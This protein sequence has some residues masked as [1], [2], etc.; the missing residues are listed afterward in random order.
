MTDKGLVP[1]EQKKVIFYEDEITAVLIQADSD[2]HVFVPL[3]PLCD[4]LGIDWPAQ[5]QRIRRDDVL[6]EETRSIVVTTTDRGD[7]EMV[8]LPL[9]FLPGWLFTISAKRVKEEFRDKIKR[10]QRECY[11][12]L[13]EAFQEGRLTAEPS[14]DELL[15]RESPAAQ[16]YR[17]ASAIMRMARQQLLLESEIRTHTEQ[18]LD[19]EQRLEEIEGTLGDP[20]RHIT[21]EQASQISQAVKSV[22][23]VLTKSSGSNQYGSVYGELYRKFGITSYKQLPA[24]RFDEALE[25]LTNWHQALV[26]DSPF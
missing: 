25:F 20:E 21:P 13:S 14:F 12:V 9:D 10:Y 22:A 23:L 18:L 8:C 17:M 4:Y 1:V 5:Y 24:K 26:G 6:S 19:H 3:R 2:R 15:D 11:R 16:A 7:R